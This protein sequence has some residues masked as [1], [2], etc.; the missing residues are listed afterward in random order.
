MFVKKNTMMETDGMTYKKAYD[1][2]K[3]EAWSDFFKTQDLTQLMEMLDESEQTIYPSPKNMFKVFQL[4]P[5]DIKVVI[6]GQD[7]YYNPGQAMGLAFSVNPKTQTPK[8]LKNIFK[9]LKNDLGVE[10]NNPDLT[11]WHKQGVFL[12]NTALSVPE[13]KPNAHKKYWKKFTNDLIQ[14]LTKVNPNIIYIMWG[15]NAKAFGQ[16]IEKI[17]NSKDLIHYAPHPSPLSSY[18]GFFNS[19]PFSWANQKLKELG[20]TEIKW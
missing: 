11:D 8:S 20:Q 9:E 6:L 2:I 3:N 18:Q 4:S 15:N 16:K 5:K 14:Y 17:L 19:K 1:T 13:K 12:L 7:P 10:R